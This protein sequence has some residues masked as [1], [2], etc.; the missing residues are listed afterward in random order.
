M[1]RFILLLLCGLALGVLPA[2]Q[3]VPKRVAV[4]DF[5]NATTDHRF[6]YV[7]TAV[8]ECFISVMSQY[9][10]VV[11]LE[12]QD[13]NQYLSEIDRNSGSRNYTRWQQLGKRL[14]ADYFVVGSVSRFGSRFLVQCR[15]FSVEKG[16]VIPG[17]A[18]SRT[19]NAEEQ[20]ID[21]VNLLGREM[22]GQ[23]RPRSAPPPANGRDNYALQPQR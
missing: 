21:I 22:V 8:P 14:G 17:T 23:V 19:C 3:L 12:R 2:C 9:P 18:R 10:A 6:D 5:E 11:M 7:S 16:R 4:M 1:P 15:L 20:I 13:I